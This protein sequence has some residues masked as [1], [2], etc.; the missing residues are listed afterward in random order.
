VVVQV[1]VQVVVV[2]VVVERHH[3]I[4]LAAKVMVAV[5]GEPTVW[6]KISMM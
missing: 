4:Q 3:Q 6:K 1:V 5:V 2:L